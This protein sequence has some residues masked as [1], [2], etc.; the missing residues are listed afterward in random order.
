MTERKTK[1]RILT[2]MHTTLLGLDS[3][4]LI[5]KRHMRELE[6]LIQSEVK[7]LKS[8]QIKSMREGLRLSQ[9]VF[10]S[11]LNTSVSTVQKWEAGQ[12]SPS[13]PSLKLLNLVKARGLEALA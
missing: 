9:A 2:E 3:E 6:A 1:S 11:L 12:K 8:T 7:P 5:D 4:G 13:G 10:A